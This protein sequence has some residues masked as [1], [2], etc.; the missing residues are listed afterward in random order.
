MNSGA[1][2]NTAYEYVG[3]NI[4][5]GERKYSQKKQDVYCEQRDN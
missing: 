4:M 2:C 3:T 1:L 5:P